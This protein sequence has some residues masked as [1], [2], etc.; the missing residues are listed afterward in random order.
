MANIHFEKIGDVWKHLPLAE[1]LSI[2]QP[3]RYW[4]SHSGSAQYPLSHSWEREYGVFYFLEHVKTSQMLRRSSYLRILGMH[5]RDGQLLEYPGSPMIA[6]ELLQQVSTEFLFCDIDR[7]SIQ[8]IK[9]TA[10]VLSLPLTRLHAVQTDGVTRLSNMAAQLRDEEITTTFVHI[11]PYDPLEK[12]ENG[13][14]SIEFFCTL[15]KREPKQYCA[16]RVRNQAI[17]GLSSC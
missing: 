6:M 16:V 5:M 11:D 2:E 14:D 3:R 4:E 10:E 12:S 17:Q 9:S 8:N 1:M 7:K 13:I 15:Y